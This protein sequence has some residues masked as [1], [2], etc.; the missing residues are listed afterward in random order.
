MS[1]SHD[2]LEHLRE[3][4]PAWAAQYERVAVTPWRAGALPHKTSAL[5]LVA[6]NASCT[7]RNAA[8]TRGA[9]RAALAAG[10]SRD[11]VLLVLKMAALLAIHACSLGAPI[12]LA[13]L[14]A[15]GDAAASSPDP[16]ATPAC[17]AMRDLGQWNPAW[18]PFLNLDPVWTD[19]FMAAE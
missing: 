2:A 17:D 14:P 1:T 15:T 11:E 9:I 5:V 10:A 6:L 12:L 19:Q 3:W 18:D 8:G 4:D 16:V 7:A 13:E